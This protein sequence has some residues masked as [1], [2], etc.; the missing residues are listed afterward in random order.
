[1]SELE[2]TDSETYIKE[3]FVDIL[4]QFPHVDF[5]FKTVNSTFK[6]D[7]IS[8]REAVFF[9]CSLPVIWCV[10]FLLLTS[11][12]LCLQCI[13][14]PPQKTDKSTCLRVSLF[15]I[16]FLSI[17]ILTPGFYGNEQTSKGVGKFVEAVKD[18]NETIT[19]AVDTL[20]TLNDLAKSISER[21]VLALEN[22]IRQYTNESVRTSLESLTNDITEAAKKARGDVAS[23]R[24]A[25][26]NIT[27]YYIVQDTTDYEFYRWIGTVVALCFTLG[28]LLLILIAIWQ[29][30][31]C[32]VMLSIFIG[33][34]TL[35]VI[36][37]SAGFYLGG[38]VAG[39]DLCY[40]P[41]LFV[42]NVTSQKVDRAIVKAY[43]ECPLGSTDPDMF[44][45]NIKMARDAVT[46]ANNT[47]YKIKAIVKPFNI[48]QLM[49]PMRRVAEE[50]EYCSGNITVLAEDLDCREIHKNYIQAVQ[51]ICNTSMLGLVFI[52]LC[53]PV[54]GLMF[55][56]TMCLLPRFWRLIGKKRGYRPVDDADPFCPRPP[57][58]NGY[59]SIHPDIGSSNSFP[60]DRSYSLNPGPESEV[61]PMHGPLAETPPP[62]YRPTGTFVENYNFGP[63]RSRYSS[64]T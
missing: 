61:L 33:F 14:K 1:M 40:D 13:R 10:I 11:C 2:A 51:G 63:S 38:T 43:I 34:L 15:I 58:Y 47:L 62:A 17:G 50:L 24:L 46:Q 5:S 42:E 22:V 4:H 3:W 21:S 60:N 16:I 30:S 12:C 39:A 7:S 31:K 23:I 56:L 59:G 27:L 19:E 25:T 32:I 55:I 6:P 9:L 26:P 8:Y 20:G 41:D 57:P 36:W 53:L 52:L 64:E 29:K 37:G 28:V 54:S 44:S 18:T 35:L 45:Q 49:E 48:P